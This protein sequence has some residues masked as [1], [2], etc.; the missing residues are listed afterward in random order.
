MEHATNPLD[1][2]EIFCVKERIPE[3]DTD[4]DIAQYANVHFFNGAILE[5]SSQLVIDNKVVAEEVLLKA[6]CTSAI[7]QSNKRYLESNFEV[8]TD[9]VAPNPMLFVALGFSEQQSKTLVYV[10]GV[11]DLPFD[12]FV[13]AYNLDG[14]NSPLAVPKVGFMLKNGMKITVEE[15]IKTF[16]DWMADND[17]VSSYYEEFLN[18]DSIEDA[19]DVAELSAVAREYGEFIE[20]DPWNQIEAACLFEAATEMIETLIMCSNVVYSLMHKKC[21]EAGIV[22][23]KLNLSWGLDD[24]AEIIL[25]NDVCT[26]DTAV[27][28]TIKAFEKTGSLENMVTKPVFEYWKSISCK[29]CESVGKLPELPEKVLDEITD[30]YMYLTEALCDDL[31]FEIHL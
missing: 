7:S 30:T 22:L 28:T 5:A 31:A 4:S 20:E 17:Y 3:L 27:M 11:D 23:A 15:A 19:I 10:R 8:K 24:D 2:Q 13:T 1:E 18:Y 6:N 29:T 12:S 26:P 21:E 16:A 9:Y 14:D 25:C